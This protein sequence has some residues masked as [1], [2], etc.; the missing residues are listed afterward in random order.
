MDCRIPGPSL[1]LH[2]EYAD[3]FEFVE[4]RT[5]WKLGLTPEAAMQRAVRNLE[6]RTPKNLLVGQLSRYSP[7]EVWRQMPYHLNILQSARVLIASFDDSMHSVRILVPR[8][9][10]AMADALNIPRRPMVIIATYECQSDTFAPMLAAPCHNMHALL[11]AFDIVWRARLF[12]TDR[13]CQQEGM[14]SCA[15]FI[16][17]DALPGTGGQI[18]A[19]YP[20][21][22]EQHAL[23]MGG[24]T[25]MPWPV[26][27][28]QRQ[29][30]QNTRLITQDLNQ[31]AQQYP[32]LACTACLR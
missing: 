11:T 12:R 8:V 25:Y 31:A 18:L 19:P 27:D 4:N 24:V 28:A 23:R 5:L 32:T 6:R 30:L 22:A 26:S 9:V 1:G 2:L 13:G 17:H 14:V 15:P 20:G 21:L 7:S 3:T 10:D 29:D 16:M